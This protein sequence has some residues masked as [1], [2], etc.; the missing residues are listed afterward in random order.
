M[1]TPPPPRRIYID[2]RLH[3]LLDMRFNEPF[4]ARG[5]FPDVIQNGSTTQA[6]QNPWANGTDATPFDQGACPPFF[7]APP[8]P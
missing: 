5:E 1:L 3:T 6:L 7:F 4:F 8:S 2:T